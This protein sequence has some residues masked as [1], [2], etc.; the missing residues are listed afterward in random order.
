MAAS[1]S[2]SAWVAAAATVLG[3]GAPGGHLLDVGRPL[4]EVQ[5]LLV[6]FGGDLPQ[7]PGGGIGRLGGTDG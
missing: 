7:H 3:L 4:L 5:S 2:R 6:R 1:A